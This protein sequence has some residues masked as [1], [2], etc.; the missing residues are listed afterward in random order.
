M[1][2]RVLHG[3]AVSGGVAIGPAFVLAATGPDP[4]A[5]GVEAALAALGRVAD[6]L[7]RSAARLAAQGRET[8]AE[9]IEANR[10]MAEDPTL[11]ADVAEAAG[12][13]SASAALR[14]ATERRADA[15][16]AL[17]DPLL[18]ARAADVRELGRRAVRALGGTGAPEPPPQ[19]SIVVASDLGPAELVDLR[20]EEGF[21]LGIALAEGSATAHAAIIARSL[22]VPMVAPW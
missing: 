3:L 1:S 14:L 11:A 8:D 15:L 16:A 19:P 12:R 6:E 10:L 2:E 17:E 9:I 7:G 20:L 4:S 13:R 21:V 18:A 5:E 22:S